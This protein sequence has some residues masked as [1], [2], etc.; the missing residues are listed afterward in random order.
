M[1]TKL[2]STPPLPTSVA[3][4]KGLARDVGG[5]TM[6][7]LGAFAAFGLAAIAMPY[8]RKVPVLGAVFGHAPSSPAAAVDQF[9]IMGA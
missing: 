6:W 5:K 8:L 9:G 3:G 4:A 7:V 1:A 2:T